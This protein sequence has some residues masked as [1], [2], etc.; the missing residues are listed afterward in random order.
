MQLAKYCNRAFP[1][2]IN[3]SYTKEM[4]YSLDKIAR[5]ELGWLTYMEIFYKNLSATV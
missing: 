5:G 4:E 2:L 3:L 1:T